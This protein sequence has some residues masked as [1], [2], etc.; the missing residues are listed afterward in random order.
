M[1][2]ITQA[3]AVVF[4]AAWLTTGVLEN[5]LYPELNR[6]FTAEVLDMARMRKE[7]PDAYALVAHRRVSNPSVQTWLFKL[8]VA[9][10]IFATLVLWAGSAALILAV[11]GRVEAASARSLA[12]LGTLS[13]TSVWVGFLVAGNWFCYWYCH[14]GAQSTHFQ[15]TLWGMATLI[16][17]AVG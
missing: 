11:F 15:M 3:A 10:E 2:L 1:L 4:L 16:L 12:L 13:F 6:V 17:I 8:I 9:W 14:E 5:V 7:Y